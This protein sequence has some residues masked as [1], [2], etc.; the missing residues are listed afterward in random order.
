MIG[1]DRTRHPGAMPPEPIRLIIVDDH[2]IVREGLRAML[3]A[4]AL[5]PVAGVAGTGQAALTLARRVV[6]T[7]A[8][9]DLRLPDMS[10]AALCRQ[11]LGLSPSISV[12]MLSTYLSEEAVREA[13]DAGACA[14]VTK[15]AGLAHL[16]ATLELARRDP[17]RRVAQHDAPRIVKELHALVAR[18]SGPP[19]PTPMQERVLELAAQGL[20]NREVGEK[21]FISESTV[22]F[23][24]QK[25]KDL[26]DARSRTDLVA[27]AIRHGLI[28]PAPED[29][30]LPVAVS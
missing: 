27:K 18:R 20:T 29:L 1:S 21:L 5:T 23:H 22:R 13:I 9:V 14:Y 17:G 16:R 24:I 26:I 28:A 12:V 8:I 25:L 3:A 10:G 19:R 30:R 11:L 4:D 7:V 2:E 15:A 6:P